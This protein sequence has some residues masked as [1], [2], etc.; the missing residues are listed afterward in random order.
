MFSCKKHPIARLCDIAEMS[1]SDM[2]QC[3]VVILQGRESRVCTGVTSCDFRDATLLF[4]RPGE[5]KEYVERMKGVNCACKSCKE[6]ASDEAGLPRG[7]LALCFCG[8]WLERTLAY[9]FDEDC[10][11]LPSWEGAC[12]GVDDNIA[13]EKVFES[14]KYKFLP[15]YSWQKR[16]GFFEYN[17]KESLHLS[18]REKMA[19]EKC[20][21]DIKDEM[22][23]G[24]DDYSNMLIAQKI[25]IFFDY[26]CRYYERQHIT[27]SCLNHCVM[28]KVERLA[29]EF[30]LSGEYHFC[31]SSSGFS[32]EKSSSSLYLTSSSVSSPLLHRFAEPL[33]MSDT[34]FEDFLC[35]ETGKSIEQYLGFRHFEVAKRLLVSSRDE[36]LCSI[37]RK[38]G[39]SST[40]CFTAAFKRV[41]GCSPS[42]YRNCC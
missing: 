21:R 2:T 3:F 42:D 10:C 29:D 12:D 7:I 13:R 38:L 20:L 23:W 31:T 19:V 9:A 8:D 11:C 36:S 41:V 16:Y 34:F 40:Q 15:R 26:C 37:A 32:G 1:I 39:Y 27:R 5:C 14:E 18:L 24:L 30:L 25:K 22:E 17:I 28:A 6:D 33:S 35:A 4:F